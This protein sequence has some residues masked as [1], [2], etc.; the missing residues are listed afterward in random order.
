MRFF[1]SNFM[2]HLKALEQKGEKVWKARIIKLK[3]EIN[4][5]EKKKKR[6]EK[7]SWLFDKNQ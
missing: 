6:K 5:I 3:A 7:K 4:K 2:A 1:I